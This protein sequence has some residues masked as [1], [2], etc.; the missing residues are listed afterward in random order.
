MPNETTHRI[1]L[2]TPLERFLYANLQKCRWDG[3]AARYLHKIQ[4]S[5]SLQVVREANAAWERANHMSTRWW[6]CANYWKNRIGDNDLE[7][8]LKL[9]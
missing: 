3:E 4:T 7:M 8:N 5:R 1:K 9:L 6:V 2:T